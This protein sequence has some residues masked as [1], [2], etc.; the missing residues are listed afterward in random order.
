[1]LDRLREKLRAM[2]HR[3]ER[4]GSGPDEQAREYD[5][6]LAHKGES[7]GP[8]DAESW[9]KDYDEGRPKH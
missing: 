8:A 6:D 5:R 7:A 9:V 3:T 4:I 1:M 2:T